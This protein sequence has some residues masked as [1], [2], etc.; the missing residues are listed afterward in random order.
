ML[1]TLALLR[2][3]LA[4]GQ[5]A[6]S[7]LLPEGAAYLRRLAV[8]LEAEGWQPAVVLTSPYLRARA[9]AA[10]LTGALGCKAPLVAL[11]ELVPEAEPDAAL[12]AIHAAAPLAT[13]V[14]VVAHLPLV[15]R[16][17]QELVGEDPGFSPGTW[18]EIAREGDGTA[19]LI[20]RIGPK[21]LAGI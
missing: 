19:R 11:D 15:G 7:D 2:H 14:L 5:A 1:R 3:G 4:G 13:P 12:A 21:D 16:I 6:G 18:V 17:A 20:R 10:V 9:S 8:K